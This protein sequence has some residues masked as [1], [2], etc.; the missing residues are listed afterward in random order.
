MNDN[1][2]ASKLFIVGLP[3]SGT[4]LLRTVINNH[5]QVAVARHET[6]FL[7]NWIGKFETVS[8]LESKQ[9]FDLFFEWCQQFPYFQDRIRKGEAFTADQWYERCDSFDLAGVFTGLIKC[10]LQVDP[11]EESKVKIWGDKSPGYT[12]QVSNIMKAIPGAR[13]IHILRDPRDNALSVNQAWGKNMIRACSDWKNGV[14]YVDK[15]SSEHPNS[16]LTVRYE[17][18]LTH[19]EETVT[20]VCEFLGVDFSPEMLVMDRAVESIGETKGQTEIIAANQSKYL[21]KMKP[22]T[23]RKIESICGE[24]AEKHGYGIQYEAG[25]RELGGWGLKWAKFCDAVN[26]VVSTVR[27][28]GLIRGLRY[29]LSF[30]KMKSARK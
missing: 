21:K 6:E 15:V 8:S 28:R 4:K 14:R 26:V 9:E 20:R 30:R 22:G 23:I 27:R 16:I 24:L 1:S 12:R 7:P 17:D 2:C 25:N 29:S 10:D 3:R 5:S 19:P 11:A 18:L 13:F